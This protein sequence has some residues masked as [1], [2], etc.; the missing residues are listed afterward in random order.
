[1]KLPRVNPVG[2]VEVPEDYQ[3]TPR[4][5]PAPL[6]WAATAL[7]ATFVLVTLTTTVVSL[8]QYCLTTDGGDV[9]HLPTLTSPFDP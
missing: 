7:L 8:G 5:W 1:M 9:R 4:Q 2:I 3:T 6:R